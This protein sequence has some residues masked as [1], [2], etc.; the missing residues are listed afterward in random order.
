MS[1]AYIAAAAM[2][3]FGRWPDQSAA[4]LGRA[5]LRS[6]LQ[7]SETG[8]KSVQAVYVGR[9]FAGAI[10][11]QV[12]VPGQVA[13][14]GTGIE[15]LPVFNF[16]NACAAVPS[17][18]HVAAGAVRSGEYDRVLVLGMDK[19]FAPERRRSMEALIGAMDVD[20]MGW[21]LESDAVNGSVF[22]ETYY[23][24]IAREY[25]ERTGATRADLASVAVKNRA[26]AALNP[27]AQYRTPVTQAEV[28]A[29]PLIC[30]PLTKLMC[31]PL[32]DGAVA[33]LVVSQ[34]EAR[35]AAGALRPVQVAASVVRSGAPQAPSSTALQRAAAQAY[36][37]AGIG[38]GDLDLAEVHEASAV[39]E[40]IATE[41]I[42]L[43]AAGDGVKLVREGRSRLGGA[44]PVNTSGGLLSRG[45]PGAA[46]GGAQLV[47]LVWQL[48]GRCGDRQ[49]AGARIGL[50]HSS[51]G[52]IGNEPACTGV[53]ILAAG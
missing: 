16:D 51:G 36:Q 24:R 40:L 44:V 4:S 26:H 7:A 11:H 34:R 45:H 13:L 25:L 35:R 22:M 29:A 53:T 41:E 50:A 48:Q 8:P 9:S 33:M 32:T 18:L 12:S 46:T 14:R 19:L 27:M 15:D 17:A 3:P 1:H 6:L 31:S 49:V 2:T 5:A 42:G 38:P 39:G 47:E 20:E 37:Q 52:L 30:D 10:D 21:M 28:L 43:A 23:G